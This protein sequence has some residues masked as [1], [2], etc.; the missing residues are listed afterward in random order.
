MYDGEFLN[1]ERILSSFK[2]LDITNNI[3]DFQWKCLYNIVYTVSR[4]QTQALVAR[5][6][7]PFFFKLSVYKFIFNLFFLILT[8]SCQY[9]YN[10]MLTTT[11]MCQP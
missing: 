6:Y 8:C 2:N 7:P 10:L 1:W 11:C 9:S 3:K 5:T 4:L